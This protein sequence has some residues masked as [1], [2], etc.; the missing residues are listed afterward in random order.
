MAIAIGVV[1]AGV[2]RGGYNLG[3]R[4]SSPRRPTHGL[5]APA[6]NKEWGMSGDYVS[7]CTR[8]EGDCHR[9]SDSL[10]LLGRWTGL[11]GASIGSCFAVQE[12]H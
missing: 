7:N 1:L 3:W 9:A 4:W 5:M 12:G 11:P 2:A 8:V 6:W 10:H